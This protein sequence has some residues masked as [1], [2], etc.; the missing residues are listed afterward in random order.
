MK[1][2]FDGHSDIFSD[3][4]DKRR[5]GEKNV[6][7]THHLNRLRKGGTEGGIFVIWI[8][9]PYTDDP[10]KRTDE[11]MESVRDELRE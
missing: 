3:V 4:T 5:K 7:R 6:I 9:P 2:V 8:D 1:R 11:I 10:E